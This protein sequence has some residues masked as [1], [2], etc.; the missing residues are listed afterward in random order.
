LVEASELVWGKALGAV[1]EKVLEKVSA[2]GT[3]GDGGGGD[4]GGSGDDDGGG[5]LAL[6]DGVD[7]DIFRR[8][9]RQSSPCHLLSVAEALDA[10][11]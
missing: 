4:D 1:L 10:Q 5:G 11:Y 2:F 8:V 7:A 9:H 6:G 3:D